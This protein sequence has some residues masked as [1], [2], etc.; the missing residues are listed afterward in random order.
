[1]L[2]LGS[3]KP[4]KEAMEVMTGEPKM[5]TGAFR[6]YFKPLEKWLMKENKKNGV[7]VGWENPPLEEMCVSSQEEPEF[8]SASIP[9]ESEEGQIE[10]I[11]AL[12]DKVGKFTKTH[13][14][15]QLF[16]QLHFLLFSSS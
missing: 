9:L 15:I 7:M 3:S 16:F 14:A 13:R 4:W 2:E 8:K 6:E 12:Q 5:D 11:K 1:M 10:A